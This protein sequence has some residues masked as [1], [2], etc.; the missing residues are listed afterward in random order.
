MFIRRGNEAS[1]QMTDDRGQTTDDSGTDDPSEIVLT[2]FHRASRG[3]T[4]ASQMVNSSNSQMV[5]N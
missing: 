2:K 1:S 3:Q 5:T 4:T